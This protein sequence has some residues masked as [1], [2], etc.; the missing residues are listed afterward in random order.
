MTH[1]GDGSGRLFVVEQGG[2]VRIVEDGRLEP[3]PWLDLRDETAPGGEQGLLGLAFHPDYAHNRRLFVNYTDLRG[4]TVVAE[5]RR[6]PSGG[7]AF[8]RVLLTIDQPFANHNGGGLAFGP[9]GFLYIATG[10]GGGAGD[11]EDN[12]Q[13][14][15]TLLGKLLRIDVDAGGNASSYGIPPDNP[16][17]GRAEARPEIWAYGLRNPWRF[18]FDQGRLWIADVGQEDLE[19]IDRAP[20]RRGGINYGWDDMEATTCYEPDVGC[21]QEGRR[22][23]LAEYSHD[24]GCSVTGGHVYRG[25]RYP[26]LSGAYIFGDYCSGTLWAVAAGGPRQQSPVELLDT[27]HLV[28]SFGVGEDAELYLTDISAGRLLQ[29]TAE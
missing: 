3:D 27:D 13:A 23:P 28:S 7:T 2:T 12:G 4:D 18:S 11:P 29:L 26:D 5:Y 10:D 15:D 25:R 19:E 14:L 20:A 6:T 24:Q 21:R 8:E 16:F 17:A 22:L 1:A 9:D